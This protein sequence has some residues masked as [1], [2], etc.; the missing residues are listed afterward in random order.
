V[1]ARGASVHQGPMSHAGRAAIAAERRVAAARG[2][3][4]V[5][6]E[7]ANVIVGRELMR[8]E[9]EATPGLIGV[10]LAVVVLVL[11]GL[12][13]GSVW[14]VA[15]LPGRTNSAGPPPTPVAVV[16]TSTPTLA[17]TS[18]VPTTTM[19]PSAIPTPLPAPSPTEA[20]APTP[21]LPEPTA[22][23]VPP[24]P[25]PSATVSP[26]PGESISVVTVPDVFVRDGPSLESSIIGGVTNGDELV[27]LRSSGAWY[28]VRVNRATSE[29]RSRIEGGQG[30]IPQDAVSPP[31]QPVP[32][33]TP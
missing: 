9:R 15:R 25:E 1:R 26:T 29:Q 5:R 28:L 11:F 30:W 31:S 19:P 21:A 20:V 4:R 16:A 2:P 10:L 32:T 24:P 14:L 6:V 12:S 3:G 8:R 17:A 18:A 7:D 22:T 27:V 13:L 23:A 33:A